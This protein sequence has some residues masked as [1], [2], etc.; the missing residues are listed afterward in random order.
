MRPAHVRNPC[1]S[2]LFDDVLPTPSRRLTPLMSRRRLLI[3]LAAAATLSAC[4]PASSNAYITGIGDQQ[5]S[6][7]TDPLFTPL[8]IKRVRYIAPYDAATKGNCKGCTIVDLDVLDSTNVNS[9]I[10]YIR[11]FQKYAKRGKPKIWGLHNYSDTNRFR[12][13]G[14][15]AVL[16]A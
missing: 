5:Y 13:K 3:A 1:V 15:K 16:K 14:T 6:M 10:K 12:N 11:T 8:H 4:A 2:N 9:T 7:F